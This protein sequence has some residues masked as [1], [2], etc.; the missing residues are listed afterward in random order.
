MSVPSSGQHGNE[1]PVAAADDAAAATTAA[2]TVKISFKVSG[3]AQFTLDVSE[4]WTVRKLK[5]KCQENTEIPVA[6]QRLIYK[7]RILK[8]D[9]LIS[10]QGLKDG[11]IMHLVKSVAAA[12]STQEQQQQQQPAPAAG[13][14]PAAPAPAGATGTT[15]GAFP[16]DP[17]LQGM[18]PGG[19]GAGMPGMGGM[20]GAMG[21]PMGAGMGGPMGLPMAGPEMMQ[22]MQSPF[23]QQAMDSL[24]QNPQMFRTIV[25][26]VP[27]LRPMLPMMQGIL[28]NPERMRAMFNPQ[29]M[30]ASMQMHQAA[31]RQQQDGT[32]GS[33]GG[34]AGGAPGA[35]GGAAMPNAASLMAALQGAA[36]SGV[37]GAPGATNTA[38]GGAPN[39]LGAY[40]AGSPALATM[41]QQA[42]EMMRQNPELVS[43]MMQSF[44]GAGGQGAAN[45]LGAF[46]MGGAGFP[47]APV[48]SRPPEERY[49]LQL[50]SLT[51]M[52]FIDRDANIAALEEANGDVNAAITRL[53]ERGLGN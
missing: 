44:M 7:G 27:A 6:A 20:G 36:G 22:M 40:G 33:D 51:D 13:D 31:M 49:A 25:E 48:D 35:A 53:L 19:L 15:P 50:Q 2:K 23:F 5:E 4:D 30:Q 21:G 43:Q 18:L 47:P 32:A 46:G 45:P 42:E 12:A 39:P 37:P 10:S 9:D 26:S 16:S 41:L 14:A 11:H 8:D 28:D 24:L 34:V 29:M 52:G 1:P 3:G 38:P 17:F